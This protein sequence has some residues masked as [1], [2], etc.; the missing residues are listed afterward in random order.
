MQTK[1]SKTGLVVLFNHNYEKNISLIKQ[2]Y[3]KRFSELKILMPFYYG[4]DNDVIGVFGN[5]YT[6]HSY[7]A[8][9]KEKIMA[10]N[11]DAIL[12]IG[13]D[14][15]LN[16]DFNEFNI[17]AKLNMPHGSFYIDNMIDISK[18]DYSR[19]LIEALNFCT[20]PAGLDSSANRFL[21]SYDQAFR[22]LN[23]KGLMSSIM[24]PKWGNIWP[25]WKKPFLSNIYENCKIF[26]K[27]L[28][29][30]HQKISLK[31]ASYPCVFGYS[32]I[33]LIPKNRMIEWC[34]HLEIMATWQ[35][36]VELAIPT[37]I[38]LLNDTHITLACSIPYK[39][40]N[41]WFPQDVKHFKQINNIISQ[42]TE[43]SNGKINA[44]HEHFPK[45]YLYLHPV[46]LSKFTTKTSA[47]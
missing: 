3:N 22:I 14:L 19:P 27:R 39:T 43:K 37:S 31:K 8:Q 47:D 18:G 4:E 1:Y 24:V 13:D 46:K 7:I 45:E 9:A 26:M 23:D 30:L 36:F 40:G 41:V 20:K 42:I 33:I 32:D 10:M 35:M 16:P 5:S 11:C 2:I 6:F 17:H 25:N 28:R 15:L 21:P 34:R 29:F 12:I 38:A 44:L